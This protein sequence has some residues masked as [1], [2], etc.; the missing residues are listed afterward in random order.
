MIPFAA[1]TFFPFTLRAPS[2]SPQRYP[3]RPQRSPSN[4]LVPIQSPFF[5]LRINVP[6]ELLSLFNGRQS[7]G[8]EPDYLRPIP[9]NLPISYPHEYRPNEFPN[10]H[11]YPFGYSPR[12]PFDA[13]SFINFMRALYPDMI[14]R[15]DPNRYPNVFAIRFAP[16]PT[17]SSN[18][19]Q[20]PPSDSYN[21][22]NRYSSGVFS[23]NIS[24]F[25]EPPPNLRQQ[26]HPVHN[27]QPHNR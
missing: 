12:L 15:P 19:Q 11:D 9:F 23:P 1:G 25:L 3:F 13:N 10:S 2:L 20:P 24:E 7:I 22:P 26:N 8:P 27:S 5:G 17:H 16:N 6:R 4:N 18:S 21:E 14:Y